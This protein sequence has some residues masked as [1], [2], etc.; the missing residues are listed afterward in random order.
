MN[1]LDVTGTEMIPNPNGNGNL[2][3]MCFGAFQ[4][5]VAAPGVLDFILGDS[6]LRNVYA[7]Y[8]EFLRN[9]N[10][11]NPYSETMLL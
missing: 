2:A 3:T 6:F 8:V 4:P 5:G 1:P 7:V 9:H 10:F 11:D